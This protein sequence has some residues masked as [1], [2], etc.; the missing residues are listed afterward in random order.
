ME[1]VEPGSAEPT[2]DEEGMSA[3]RSGDLRLETD[4]AD[5]ESEDNCR[6]QQDDGASEDGRFSG[7]DVLRETI[8]LDDAEEAKA[9]DECLL[10]FAEL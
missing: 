8:I 1:K 5:S 2:E 6:D 7:D 3:L 4:A 10:L 9:E